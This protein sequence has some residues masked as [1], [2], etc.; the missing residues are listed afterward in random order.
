MDNVG[1]SHKKVRPLP[2]EPDALLPEPG[3]A[4]VLV[5]PGKPNTRRKNPKVKKK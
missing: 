3:S 5:L 1:V 2:Y 4:A